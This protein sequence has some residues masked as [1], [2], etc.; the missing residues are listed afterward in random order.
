MTTRV[1]ERL[2]SSPMRYT[3]VM[4]KVHT[5]TRWCMVFISSSL[6]CTLSQHSAEFV[7][8]PSGRHPREPV[9]KRGARGVKRGQLRVTRGGRASAPTEHPCFD[10]GGWRGGGPGRRGRA[11]LESYIPHYPFDSLS[12]Y[13][14]TFTLGLMLDTS[15]TL[16]HLNVVGTSYASHDIFHSPGRDA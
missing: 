9:P 7:V 2:L 8:Q 15:H 4:R 1:L 16:L 6:G 13:A 14:P 3:S 11:D 12:G 10:Y 5:I